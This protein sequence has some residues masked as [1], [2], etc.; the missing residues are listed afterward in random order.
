VARAET[1]PLTTPWQIGRGWP[2]PALRS[3]RA[4]LAS[5][6][7]SRAADPPTGTEPAA[8]WTAERVRAPLGHEPPGLPLPDGLFARAR[9]ALQEYR[10]ADPRIT[11]GHFD[12]ASPLLGRDILVEVRVLL[13]HLLVGLRIGAVL[14]EADEQETRLGIR[15]DTLQGHILDGAEWIEIAKDHRTGTIWLRI[16]V[17]WRPGRLPAWWMGLGL[18]LFGHTIQ[19]R[20]RRQALRRLRALAR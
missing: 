16:A 5:R 9:R 1:P 12:P 2:E 18:R 13:I 15:L 8:T 3:Q 10:F 20:W 14:D 11:R 19:A 17:R 7:A 4:A 6:A